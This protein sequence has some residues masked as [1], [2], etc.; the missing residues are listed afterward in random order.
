MLTD[1]FPLAHKQYSRLPLFGSVLDEFAD[2]LEGRGYHRG[3]GYRHIWTTRDVDRGLRIQG[4]NS[5]S[6]ITR[7]YL[8][9]IC[10]KDSQ[11]NIS[12]ASTVRIWE[13]Y[14]EER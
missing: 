6:E 10:P 4:C 1:L 2:W 12:L 3:L 14:L 7:E 5:L 11:E 9:S 13:R 8:D